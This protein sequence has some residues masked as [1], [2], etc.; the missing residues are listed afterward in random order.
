MN[1]IRKKRK[2][3]HYTK[4]SDYCPKEDFLKRRCFIEYAP[5]CGDSLEQMFSSLEYV[6]QDKYK[7][8]S[9]EEVGVSPSDICFDI[10]TSAY[11]W[12]NEPLA[13]FEFSIKIA[14]MNQ[15]AIDYLWSQQEKKNKKIVA[16]YEKRFAKW[17]E[18]HDEFGEA[19]ALQQKQKE[20]AAAE[21]DLKAAQA[22]L[23]KLKDKQ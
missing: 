17:K 12:D 11:N 2:P 21:R 10:R 5:S 18:W 6:A 20:K 15:E 13:I 1:K 4:D 22:K 16:S 8:S 9:L 19:Y 14:D 7:I 3:K 23:D